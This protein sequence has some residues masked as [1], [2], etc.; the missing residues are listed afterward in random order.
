MPNKDTSV[1][2]VGSH[3]YEGDCS[4]RCPY[5]SEIRPTKCDEAPPGKRRGQ[6]HPGLAHCAYLGKTD[7]DIGSASLLW[8][9]IKE[10]GVNK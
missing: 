7:E 5:W 4:K 1:I 8:D 2:P 3:C 6:C 9:Q 10:C